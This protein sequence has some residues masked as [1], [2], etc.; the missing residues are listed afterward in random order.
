[1]RKNGRFP[2]TFP[3]KL[4]TG[5]IRGWIDREC[6]GDVSRAARLFGIDEG[7]LRVV[8]QSDSITFDLADR[9][10]CGIGL[11]LLWVCDPTLAKVY[12]RV[13]KEADK[14]FPIAEAA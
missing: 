5:H 2:S 13:V 12:G 11:P 4:V 1:M 14:R 8:L 7:R 6:G 9:L 10:L 3:A